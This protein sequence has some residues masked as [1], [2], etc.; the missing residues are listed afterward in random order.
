MPQPQCGPWLIP[1]VCEGGA[2]AAG[3]GLLETVDRLGGMT[4]INRK[5]A[6]HQK[7]VVPFVHERDT[8]STAEF[9]IVQRLVRELKKTV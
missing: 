7:L 8:V 6:G 5:Y 9:G 3:F 2:A 1:G 4:R